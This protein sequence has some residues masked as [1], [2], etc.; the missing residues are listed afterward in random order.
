MVNSKMS[1]MERLKAPTPSFFKKLR[2][3]GLCLTA[4]GGV[5]I[6]APIA[7]PAMVV[8]VA[9]Y[10]TVAGSVMTAVSQATVEAE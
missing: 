5:L 2:N 7:L 8:T 6:A 1:L 3:V 4:A 10:I 9:G